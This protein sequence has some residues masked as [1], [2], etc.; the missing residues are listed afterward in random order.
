MAAACDDGFD[1]EARHANARRLAR[2]GAF[3]GEIKH[4]RNAPQPGDVICQIGSVCDRVGVDQKVGQ[5]AVDRIEPGIERRAVDAVGEGLLGAVG[6]QRPD[7]EI[8]LRFGR[9]PGAVKCA[10]HLG[11]AGFAPSDLRTG[12]RITDII[13]A[14]PAILNPQ[15]GGK[16]RLQ[17]QPLGKFRIKKHGQ[18][19]IFLREIC[20]RSSDSGGTIL[21]QC[22]RARQHQRGDD[23][24]KAARKCALHLGSC[25]WPIIDRR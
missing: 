10:A 9:Q 1:L 24:G 3:D 22:G 13:P 2:G 11:H 4:S 23:S 19:R 17:F 5:L 12:R 15:S 25:R 14:I 16:L 20:A 21:R 8:D 18:A 7:I 6:L